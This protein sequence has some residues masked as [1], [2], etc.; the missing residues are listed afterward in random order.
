MCHAKFEINIAKYHWFLCL[1]AYLDAPNFHNAQIFFFFFC[2][3]KLFHD[4]RIWGI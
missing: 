4:F 1:I 3:T 2:G